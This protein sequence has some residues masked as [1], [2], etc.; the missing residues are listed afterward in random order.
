MNANDSNVSGDGGKADDKVV[1]EPKVKPGVYSVQGSL[2]LEGCGKV[3]SIGTAVKAVKPGDEVTFD[4]TAG[5]DVLL[6]G[7]LL[8][9]LAENEITPA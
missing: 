5:Q 1:V 8:K 6:F 9:I 4:P 2:L 3:V 7:K